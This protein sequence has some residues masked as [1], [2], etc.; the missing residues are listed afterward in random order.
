MNRI[1]VINDARRPTNLYTVLL[2]RSLNIRSHVQSVRNFLQN[3]SFYVKQMCSEIIFIALFWEAIFL[4]GHILK[5]I[6]AHC[7]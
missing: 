3:Q 2:V 4:I 1:I 7:S 6:L 5:S